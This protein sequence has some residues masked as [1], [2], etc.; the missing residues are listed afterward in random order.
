MVQCTSLSAASNCFPAGQRP[1]GNNMPQRGMPPFWRW[2][3]TPAHDGWGL[4]ITFCAIPNISS[5]AAL[6]MILACDLY[7]GQRPSMAVDIGTNGEVAVGKRIAS[8]RR[9]TPQVAPL[10]APL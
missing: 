4:V 8:W 7:K 3:G 9:R 2:S 10:R 5:E 6:G 1:L